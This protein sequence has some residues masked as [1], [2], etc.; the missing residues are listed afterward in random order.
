MLRHTTDLAWKKCRRYFVEANSTIVVPN[1]GLKK[2]NI[3]SDPVYLSTRFR[4][5]SCMQRVVETSQHVDGRTC[6]DFSVDVEL[7]TSNTDYSNNNSV[8]VQVRS[9]QQKA[10]KMLHQ[11]K[12]NRINLKLVT[13]KVEELLLLFLSEYDNNIPSDG[14]LALELLNTAL[15]NCFSQKNERLLPRLFSLTCQVM[16]RSDYTGATINE[17]HRQLWRLLNGHEQYFATNDIRYNT[18]HVNDVCSYFIRHIVVNANKE[19]RK[20]DTMKSIQL[21]QLIDRLAELYCDPSVPLVANPYIDDS[22]IMLLCNQHKPREAYELL[23]KRVKISQSSNLCFDPLVSSFT[24]TI[25]GYAKTSQPENALQ[26]VEWMLLAQ[27]EESSKRPLANAVK[28]PPPNVSCFNALLHAYARA[29]GDDAGFKA[30]QTLEWMEQICGSEHLD[31]MPNNI[32][33]N[34]CINA[35]ARSNHPDAHIR[36]EILL[37][38]IVSLGEAGNQV[39]PSEEAFTAVMNAWVNRIEKK[40]IV[41]EEVT[42]HVTRILDLMERISDDSNRLALSVVPYSVLIKAWEKTAQQRRGLEKQKCVDKVLQVVERMLA[43]GVAPRTEMYNSIL[44]ALGEIAPI[45][46]VFY[47]LELEQQYCDG[48]IQLDTQTFNCGLNAIAALNRPDAVQKATDILKRMFGY[49]RTDHSILPSTLTFNIIL[50]VLSRSTSHTPDA[51]VKADDLLTEM[52]NMPSVTPD[53]ISYVTCIIAWGRSFEKNKMK[54]VT[55]L[56]H[57]YIS[58]VEKRQDEECKSNIAV[59]NA[60]LS[61]CHHNLSPE[62]KVESLDAAQV[63]MTELLKMKGVVPDQITYSSFFRVVK[64]GCPANIPPTDSFLDLIEKNFIRCT[65]DGYIT[66]DI[67]TAIFHVVPASVFANIVGENK[68]PTTLSIPKAWS[69]KV[70]YLY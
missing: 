60:V 59:F 49:H 34:T 17:V 37:R 63:T 15:S 21:Q 30:E 54:R 35:W 4:N 56:L 36:A 16:I 47:F 25:N 43:K 5:Y 20:L 66:R 24:S 39:G 8:Q 7:S 64:E 52:D 38:R 61:V 48:T 57:R 45:N 68:D 12:A 14:P 9:Y 29:G 51:A 28:I 55:N 40:K 33:Y 41:N 26:I 44:T 58:S 10:K 13:Q 65:S 31:T 23:Q 42:D 22:V 18:H 46:A 67:L 19:K 11:V 27:K 70:N 69:R 2:M 32:S 1:T 3:P 53:F 6:R 62:L 50:K